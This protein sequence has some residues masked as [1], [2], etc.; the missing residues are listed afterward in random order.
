[1]LF[2]RVVPV[3]LYLFSVPQLCSAGDVLRRV[4]EHDDLQLGS[5]R[6]LQSDTREHCERRVRRRLR[7]QRL[8]L[9]SHVHRRERLEWRVEWN[10]LQLLTC[11]ELLFQMYCTTQ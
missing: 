8:L 6:Q 5:N 1:M 9:D 3:L 2:L 4:A 11:G 10:Q 7:G